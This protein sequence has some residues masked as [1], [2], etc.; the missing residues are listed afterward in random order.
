MADNSVSKPRH[1]L[2]IP[3]EKAEILNMPERLELTWTTNHP[4]SHYG[5]GVMLNPEKEIL[6]GATFRIYRD[7]FGARIET[8]QPEK[9]SHALGLAFDESGIGRAVD[10]GKLKEYGGRLVDTD[11]RLTVEL[12]DPNDN[13]RRRFQ[14]RRAGEGIDR[15]ILQSDGEPML[16][17]SPW[18]P[19]DLAIMRAARGN[20]H[21]ILDPLGF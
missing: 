17:G 4:A 15:R 19:C 11:G 1:F 14:Y 7:T 5:L 16:D 6:D 12:V 10:L 21:P 13:A 8:D 2:I 20:Y 18:E 3:A 9:V